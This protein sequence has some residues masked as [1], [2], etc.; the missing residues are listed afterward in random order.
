MQRSD[1]MD[2][3]KYISKHFIGPRLIDFSS[4]LFLNCPKCT[5]IQQHSNFIHLVSVTIRRYFYQFVILSKK[6][7]AQINVKIRFLT[8]KKWP[9]SRFEFQWYRSTIGINNVRQSTGTIA[10]SRPVKLG[11]D[12]SLCIVSGVWPDHFF[13]FFWN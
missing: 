11:I 5:S 2:L 3:I 4:P 9:S 6:L 8:I 1:R 10:R 13:F 7:A 12:A